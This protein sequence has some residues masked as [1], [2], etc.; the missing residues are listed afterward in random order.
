M[1]PIWSQPAGKKFSAKM[2][3][4]LHFGPPVRDVLG[5]HIEH[6]RSQSAHPALTFEWS[7]LYWSCSQTDSGGHFKD[8][9]AG[10]Y[11]VA[12][13][14]AIVLKFDAAHKFFTFK[15]G[16]NR[17]PI[18]EAACNW[19]GVNVKNLCA[20]SNWRLLPLGLKRTL[21]G[22]WGRQR[23]PQIINPPRIGPG[24]KIPSEI[25]RM[26]REPDLPRRRCS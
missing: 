9:G 14:I 1:Q 7:N 26:G 23:E 24:G 22:T 3:G 25:K 5:Q 6:F 12:D 4:H 11:N 18:T 21:G 15:S 16:L 20:A 13:L 2:S 19:R 8:N 10:P 17:F